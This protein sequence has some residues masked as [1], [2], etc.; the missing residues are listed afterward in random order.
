M[1]LMYDAAYPPSKPFPGA[2]AVAGY[3]GGTTPNV[4][5][6]D[7]WN[8]ASDDGRL[9]MLP[10]WSGYLE[11]NPRD[12]AASAVRAVQ[13]LGWRPHLLHHERLIVLDKETQTDTVWQ[14]QFAAEISRSGFRC[15]NYRSV[16]AITAAPSPLNSF[17]WPADWD[18]NP[19]FTM[20]PDTLAFQFINNVLWDGTRVDLSI[21]N[22]EGYNRLGR[23]ARI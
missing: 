9:R 21:L 10:I 20:E 14:T 22:E 17:N 7:E 18:G 6:E 2:S 23:H 15:L 3:V 8:A 11:D 19:S 1:Y 5:N 12:H 16:S 13:A 4:W